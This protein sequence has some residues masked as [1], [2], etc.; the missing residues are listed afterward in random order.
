MSAD[1][2]H[3]FRLLH[4]R[5]LARPGLHCVCQVAGLA[6]RPLWL[7]GQAPDLDRALDRC[8]GLSITCCNVDEAVCSYPRARRGSVK[9]MCQHLVVIVHD[10]VNVMRSL[11]LA[12]LTLLAIWLIV[13]DVT[14]SEMPSFRSNEVGKGGR[15]E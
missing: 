15:L 12:M 2:H 11:R 4:H 14:S 3:G 6:C 10:S 13:V 9:K 5:R 7:E 1:V 8:L